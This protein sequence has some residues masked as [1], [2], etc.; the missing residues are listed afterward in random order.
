MRIQLLWAIEVML[1][2]LQCYD[3]RVIK[4]CGELL[5]FAL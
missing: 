5:K 2:L 3:A 1:L 4:A